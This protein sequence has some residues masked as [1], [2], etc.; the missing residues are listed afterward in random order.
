MNI[1]RSLGV[2]RWTKKSLNESQIKRAALVEFLSH[3]YLFENSGQ[4]K[5]WFFSS[6]VKYS[7]YPS[8]EINFLNNSKTALHTKLGDRREYFTQQQMHQIAMGADVAFRWCNIVLN[9][10]SQAFRNKNHEAAKKIQKWFVNDEDGTGNVQ[11]MCYE[12]RNGFEKIIKTLRSTR[13]TFTDMPSNRT[14]RGDYTDVVAF[15]RSNRYSSIS[16]SAKK[17]CDKRFRFCLIFVIR[18]IKRIVCLPCSTRR[19][20]NKGD[21]SKYSLFKYPS[22]NA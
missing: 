17:S 20:A 14:D 1:Y 11:E 12:L 7:Q 13:L 19:L 3:V 18:L 22:S 16:N 2:A 8:Q 5:V 15:V 6:P 21:I 10:L 4:V 9:Q